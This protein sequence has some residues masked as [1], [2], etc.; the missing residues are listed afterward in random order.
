MTPLIP[1]PILNYVLGLTRLPARRFA[2]A[3]LL[4]ML[5]GNVLYAYLGSRAPRL[6]EAFSRPELPGAAGLAVAG[7]VVA[8]TVLVV[9]LAGRRLARDLREAEVPPPDA[10]GASRG[11]RPQQAAGSW[12]VL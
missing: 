5:P 9:W 12:D 10:Q 7:G 11:P 3:S 8:F 6:A 2:L 4:G 1:F